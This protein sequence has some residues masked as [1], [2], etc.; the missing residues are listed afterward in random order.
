MKSGDN[1]SGREKFSSYFTK[2][3]SMS[4]TKTDWLNLQY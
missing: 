3:Y 2:I 1:L 4:V